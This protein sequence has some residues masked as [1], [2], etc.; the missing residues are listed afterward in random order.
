[1]RLASMNASPDRMVP[2]RT[3]RSTVAVTAASCRIC[4]ASYTSGMPG[5][6]PSSYPNA[7]ASAPEYRYS[8]PTTTSP[9]RTSSPT[10]PALPALMTARGCVPWMA[11][12]AAVAEFT[13]PIPHCTSSTCRP[14]TVSRRCSA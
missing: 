7:R 9:T 13:R 2:V 3:R 11:T 4:S 8:D 1:M 6:W 12:A 10:P 14:Q 5:T